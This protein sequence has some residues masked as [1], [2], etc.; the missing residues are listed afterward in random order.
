VVLPIGLSCP[1]K[2]VVCHSRIGI[3]DGRFV[4]QGGV[5]VG[6][7]KWQTSVS[8]LYGGHFFDL[9]A[10]LS[11]ARGADTLAQLAILIVVHDAPQIG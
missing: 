11:L 2:F 6:M 8:P 7:L 1:V 4:V 5:G 9:W 3:P 10:K